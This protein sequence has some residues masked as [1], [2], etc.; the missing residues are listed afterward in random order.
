MN[1]LYEET[2]IFNFSNSQAQKQLVK[3]HKFLMV[4]LPAYQETCALVDLEVN[5]NTNN[6]KEIGIPKGVLT[7]KGRTNE[8]LGRTEFI[9]FLGLPEQDFLEE[10][11]N[12][13]ATLAKYNASNGHASY[14]IF[15]VS[16]ENLKDLILRVNE[17]KYAMDLSDS[18]SKAVKERDFKYHEENLLILLEDIAKIFM[19]KGDIYSL[20]KVK[21]KQPGEEEQEV[22]LFG[23]EDVKPEM[24]QSTVSLLK[25]IFE[26][27][28]IYEKNNPLLMLF[29]RFHNFRYL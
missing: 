16:D 19:E 2:R 14:G 5:P 17:I 24:N 23:E 27:D 28:G 10:K 3:L 12:S 11:L 8:K 9:Y 26:G 7:V 13:Q 18:K 21:I 4:N 29:R 22:D 25:A 15:V 6:E 1:K 20:K